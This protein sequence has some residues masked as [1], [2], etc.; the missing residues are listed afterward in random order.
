MILSD[1]WLMSDVCRVHRA[2]SRTRGL[3][4]QNWHRGSPRHTW[5]G[6]HFQGQKVKGQRSRPLCSPPCWRVRRLHRRRENVMAGGRHNMSPPRTWPWPSAFW[7]W[8]W[9][10]NHVWRGI[11]LCQF[12]VFKGLSVLDLGPMCATDVRQTD[13]RQTER[14]TDRRQTRIIA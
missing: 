8:K 3:K 12:L 14:Q 5:L 13:V 1:V 7:P 10:S 9:C 11:P 4:D 6:H 2:K